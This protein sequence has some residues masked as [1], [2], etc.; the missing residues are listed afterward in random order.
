MLRRV[1]DLQIR[2]SANRARKWFDNAKDDTNQRRLSGTVQTHQGNDLTRMDGQ[3]D[4]IQHVPAS[5]PNAY[6]VN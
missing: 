4:L 2:S 6:A 1:S 5:K 3:M